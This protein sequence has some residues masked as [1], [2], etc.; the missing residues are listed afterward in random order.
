[1]GKPA[2]RLT[3]MNVCPMVTGIVQHVGGPI[4][5]P[6]V[7]TVM[8]GKMPAATMCD[9]VTCTG[10]PDTIILGSTGVTIGGKPAARMGDICAHGG[11]IILGCMTVLIGETMPGAP[12]IPTPPDV[13]MS[14]LGSMDPEA[15]VKASQIAELKEAAVKGQAIVHNA[16]TCPI[17]SKKG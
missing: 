14:V 2:A 17:C 11:T 10:P 9:L 6:G 5:G 4:I 7:P 13:L 16:S 15:A 8:I 1:M 12:L 3:D